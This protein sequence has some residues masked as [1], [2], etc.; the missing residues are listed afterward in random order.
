MSTIKV[1]GV[2]DVKKV[3]TFKVAKLPRAGDRIFLPKGGGGPTESEWMV[4]N[5]VHLA[6]EANATILSSDPKRL[7]QITRQLRGGCVAVIG[8]VE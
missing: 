8:A 2:S 7:G 5:I 1:T 3:G 4:V 6:F